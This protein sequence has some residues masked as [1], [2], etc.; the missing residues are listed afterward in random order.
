[1]CIRDVLSV[2]LNFI[3]INLNRAFDLGA[4]CTKNLIFVINFMRI[5]AFII[6]NVIKKNRDG[7]GDI[8]QAVR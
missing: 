1:M 4:Q 5:Y 8:G 2:K 3:T 7:D 6:M